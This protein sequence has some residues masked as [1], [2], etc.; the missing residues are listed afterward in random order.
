MRVGKFFSDQHKKEFYNLLIQADIIEEQDDTL[1]KVEEIEI[2]SL[3]SKQIAFFYLIALY[4]EDFL[5]YEGEKFWVES[6]EEISLDGPVYLLEDK[7][8]EPKNDY[9]IVI[10]IGKQILRD[11]DMN[12]EDVPNHMKQYIAEM[13]VMLN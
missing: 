2:G 10:Y 1:Y 5:H 7:I 13:I 11:M 3:L 12:I 4:Q 6:Y 8:G 9:E